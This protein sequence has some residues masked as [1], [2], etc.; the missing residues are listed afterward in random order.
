ASHEPR[1]HEP[2]GH[3]LVEPPASGQIPSTL[4]VPSHALHEAIEQ[5]SAGSGGPTSDGPTSDGSTGEG[6]T[7][8]GLANNGPPV[9]RYR[10]ERR[11]PTAILLVFDDGCA[12]GEQLRIRRTPF[13]VGR[14]DGDLV[15]GHDQ[16]MSRRHFR[17][18]RRQASDGSGDGPWSWLLQDLDSLNGTF[19][20]RQAV[21]IG[22]GDQLMLGN[23]VLRI[24]QPNGGRGGLVLTKIG[25]EKPPERVTI[26]PG[27]HY[28][29]AD[30]QACLPMLQGS[31][32]LA[33]RHLRL[34]CDRDHRWTATAL[35]AADGVW[36]RQAE[37]ALADGSSWQCG[38]QRFAFRLP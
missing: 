35:G 10:P 26:E 11:P 24:E 21:G 3:T 38:E 7:G 33:P 13:D 15:I 25:D 32:L 29:G 20:R 37:L 34:E 8:E 14:V 9:P 27:T 12:T 18:T 23:E 30:A 1:S 6:S 4:N 16:Q 2:A 5:A 17:I 28:L 19:I 31:P 22:D 36:L